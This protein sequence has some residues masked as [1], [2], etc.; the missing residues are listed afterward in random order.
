MVS[1][2]KSRNWVILGL[3]FVAL[4][5]CSCKVENKKFNP[6]VPGTEPDTMI[7]L[8]ATTSYINL[9]N[10][11]NFYIFG[12]CSEVGNQVSI[13]ARDNLGAVRSPNGTIFCSSGNSWETESGK[14]LDLTTLADGNIVITAIH[15][16][17]LAQTHQTVKNFTKDIVRPYVTNIYST[18]GSGSYKLGQEIYIVMQFNEAVQVANSPKLTLGADIGYEKAVYSSGAGTSLLT[19]KY[20]VLTGHNTTA[21]EY[22]DRN[23]LSGDVTDLAG[24]RTVTSNVLPA[25][26]GGNSLSDN[27]TIIVDTYV[28]YVSG[29]T[30]TA[31][32]G[33]TRAAGDEIYIKVA[34][35]EPVVVT[36]TSGSTPYIN[37][38]VLPTDRTASYDSVSST[39]TIMSFK[40]TVQAEDYTADRLLYNNTTSLQLNSAV[41]VDSAQNAFLKDLPDPGSS[42]LYTSNVSVN[43]QTPQ[44]TSVTS[45]VADGTY[46]LGDPDIDI[47]LHFSKAVVVTGATPYVELRVSDGVSDTGTAPYVGGS[48]SNTLVFNYTIRNYDESYGSSL[49]YIENNLTTSKEGPLNWNGATIED[50]TGNEINW[51]LPTP[52]TVGS[53]DYGR[54][55]VVDSKRPFLTG[56]SS[57][58][59]TGS[60]VSIDGTA[61]LT[62]VFDEDVVVTGLP[63]LTINATPTRTATYFYGSGS[64]TLYFTYVVREGD[65]TL[66]ATLDYDNSTANAFDLVAGVND[67]DDVNGNNV[68]NS[69]Q[70]SIPTSL[71][72]VD[73]TIDGIRPLI[74]TVTTTSTGLKLY[75]DTIDIIITTTATPLISSATAQFTLNITNGAST[76]KD[77]DCSSVY[78]NPT[79]TWTCPY[80]VAKGDY[81]SAGGY[82]EYSTTTPLKNVTDEAGNAIGGFPTAGAT[83]SLS[84]PVLVQTPITVDGVFPDVTNVTAINPNGDY[85]LNDILILEVQFDDT[86]IV[87]LSGGTPYLVLDTNTVVTLDGTA[88]YAG[89]SGTANL[90]FQY[91]IKQGDS[92]GHLPNDYLDYTAS[93]SLVLSGGQVSD[94]NG[95]TMGSDELAL[96][97]PNTGTAGS[98]SIAKN[99]QIEIDASIPQVVMVSST[100]VN[101]PTTMYGTTTNAG[102]GNGNIPIIITFDED[103]TVIGSPE[104]SL[105]VAGRTADYFG[106]LSNNQLIFTYPVQAGDSVVTCTGTTDIA[107]FNTELCD[108]NYTST[109]SLDANGGDIRDDYGNSIFVTPPVSGGV[110]PLPDTGYSLKKMNDV[111]IDTFVP[112]VIE[113]RS[114]TTTGATAHYVIGELVDIEVEFNEEVRLTV[115][116]SAQLNLNIGQKASYSSGANTKVLTFRYVVQDGDDTG[117]LRFNGLDP[118]SVSGGSITDIA[119]NSIDVTTFDPSG[120]I[121]NDPI[122]LHG[123][124]PQVQSVLVLS[125]DPIYT[126][127]GGEQ[128]QIAVNFDENV[129]VGG[130][131]ILRLNVGGTNLLGEAQYS[132]TSGATITFVYNVRNGDDGGTGTGYTPAIAS[133][134]SLLSND[135]TNGTI[136]DSSNYNNAALTLPTLSLP[137]VLI[138]GERPYAITLNASPTKIPNIF[139]MGEQIDIQIGFHEEIVVTGTPELL[140]S[141]IPV[142]SALCERDGVDNTLLVCHYTVQAGDMTAGYLTY[143]NSSALT[144]T[145]RDING[146]MANLSMTLGMS[147]SNVEVNGATAIV[148][149]VTSSKANGRYGVGEVIDIRVD[150]SRSIVVGGG[151]PQLTLLTNSS[152]SPLQ[153]RDL[154]CFLD[155]SDDSVLV[156]NFTVLNGDY[157]S[158][159]D[160]YDTASLKHNGSTIRTSE[161]IGG[162]FR[163]ADLTLPATGSLFSLGSQD[164]VV[165]AV[166]PI[167]SDVD[168]GSAY[169][170]GGYYGL[171]T[172]IP[173]EVTF[174]TSMQT[175]TGGIPAVG[176]SLSGL[177]KEVEC[178]L[179]SVDLT[180]MICLY[181][182]ATGDSALPLEV[183][184]VGNGTFHA[185]GASLVDIDG[186]IMN[187]F[188]ISLPTILATRNII[189]DTIAPIVTI[190]SPS[191]MSYISILDESSFA[192]NGLCTMPPDGSNEVSLSVVTGATASLTTTA[193]CT[194]IGVWSTTLDLSNVSDGLIQLTATQSD[195]AGNVSYPSVRLYQKVLA[196]DAGQKHNHV[197]SRGQIMAWGD[198]G[199]GRL[200]DNSTATRTVPVTLSAIGSEVTQISSGWDH[201]CAIVASGKVQ[202]WGK[203]LNGQ[204][205]DNTKIQ[206]TQPSNF[207]VDSSLADLTGVI[208]IVTGQ[209]YSCA[210]TGSGSV[211]CWGSNDYGQLGINADFSAESLFAAL[212]PSL[213]GVQS[214]YGGK[215]HV[216]AVKSDQVYCWGRNNLGQLGN[217]LGD[218]TDDNNSKVP[219]IV[220]VLGGAYRTY[221]M[222]LGDSHTCA[223]FDGAVKCWGS[224]AHGQLGSGSDEPPYVNQPQSGE[225]V[226]GLA[227]GSNVLQISAG[228]FHTCVMVDNGIKCWG[229]NGFGRLGDSTNDNRNV[230]TDVTGIAANSGA[231]WISAGSTHSC[232]IVSGGVKC[233]GNG[234]DGQLGNSQTMEQ[235]S[236]RYVYHL[237]GIQFGAGDYHTC[238]HTRNGTSCWGRGGFGQLGNDNTQNSDDPVSVIID[239]VIRDITGG[240]SLSCSVVGSG[241]KCWGDNSV[242]QVGNGV[243]GGFYETPQTVL[244]P[245]PFSMTGVYEIT[246]GERHSC[247]RVS[248][249]VKC[250]GEN[251]NGQLGDN[252]G[253][254]NEDPV[255]VVDVTSTPIGNYGT[256][257]QIDSDGTFGCAIVGVTRI[258]Y[259]WGENGV[260]PDRLYAAPLMA[261]VDQ[262]DVGG[263]H[264]CAIVNDGVQCWGDNYYGQLGDNNDPNDSATAVNVEDSLGVDITGVIQ[265]VSGKYHSCAIT[266]DTGV[267]CWGRNYDGQ[268]GDATNIDR[269]YAVDVNGLGA[270]AGVLLLTAGD[271][272]TCAILNGSVKCWGKNNY[273]QLGNTVQT[274]SNV[275]VPVSNISF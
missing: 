37:L 87:D 56:I 258:A 88:V 160:Y 138:D 141:T 32:P 3:M 112:T 172:T 244:D 153:T 82:L 27:N 49:R 178:Y 198:N 89:G 158:D 127:D 150:F 196:L 99:R 221:Q 17:A 5:V 250:W 207:V 35:T 237:T 23:S 33:E 189:I 159:L 218:G 6:R 154:D 264:T 53:L 126:I 43:A 66:G 271:Y 98:G 228:D 46:K 234:S 22:F 73:I 65:V 16:D 242:G 225:Y 93:N 205:G 217:G 130:I 72:Y 119:S 114:T 188:N 143:A 79:T 40:Y 103:V 215:K 147:P 31:T 151:V 122:S 267:K 239:G 137:G 110:L 265:V 166:P 8:S 261:N 170:G 105:N 155:G 84:N 58:N 139:Y 20:T 260:N 54:A 183:F 187:N 44:I 94:S 171:G 208:Q 81:I 182:V 52:G 256:I 60:I 67:I 210:L 201:S 102:Y 245:I 220:P 92:T 203:N 253:A 4:W 176:L 142:R 214:I 132:S 181:A 223:I 156:C 175:P 83:G 63:A 257:F 85:G 68:D 24:N 164:I 18:T 247:A 268:L 229:L 262:L 9:A 179:D 254:D 194:G 202:C 19:F 108:L 255:E 272:H 74:S 167:V 190:A 57:I 10:Y 76:S 224:N 30:T 231:S 161:L 45:N 184:G 86:V 47:R 48:G 212:I 71:S 1:T 216:C 148:E 104:I 233:W 118:V 106:H 123:D 69:Y 62:A 136:K 61:Y 246:S 13:V 90:Q 252:T 70:G 109:S 211:Y 131:P 101:Y 243:S 259:C 129:L 144:G 173:I 266:T 162:S 238:V 50:S 168:A 197:I 111:R 165:N 186:N 152:T 174:T 75:N 14:E 227:T 113:V 121:D 191:M 11:T 269:D 270:A 180:K 21:L 248:T 15:S 125:A 39:A 42:G 240:N 149:Q 273:G 100:A 96:F 146:N 59:A 36:A 116:A 236:P 64:N 28:P 134:D 135:G 120:F 145:I 219:V 41:V 91:Q 177:E 38:N 115:G 230:P 97:D 222:A 241:A 263:Y 274:G 128:L 26:G 195:I 7:T 204:L 206:R 95:N 133:Y 192:V 193:S 251:V 249:Q 78:A 51:Y 275:P 12:A 169:H 77:V 200:G 185:N 199:S 209:A 117:Q 34:L 140:L 157:N 29:V 124:V 55:I 235:Y 2:T 213:T 80:T 25:I 163:D 232:A 107:S 226:T